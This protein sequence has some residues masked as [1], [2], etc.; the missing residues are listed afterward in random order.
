MEWL[1]L[2][3]FFCLLWQCEHYFLSLLLLCDVGFGALFPAVKSLEDRK[4]GEFSTSLLLEASDMAVVFKYYACKD[5]Y[6]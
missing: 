6:S 2:N 3:T 4:Q 5:A 1:G